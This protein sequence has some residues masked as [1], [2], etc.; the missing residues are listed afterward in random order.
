[1]GGAKL[2]HVPHVLA[3]VRH[4]GPEREV[5][6]HSAQNWRTLFAQSGALVKKARAYSKNRK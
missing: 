6:N 4:H 2:T 1:M 5:Y 3:N